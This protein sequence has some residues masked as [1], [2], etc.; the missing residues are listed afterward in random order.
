M[1]THSLFIIL[2]V[3][4]GGFLGA[5][6]RY[7]LGGCVMQ[8]TLAA[9]FPWSTFAV[10][11]LGCILMGLLAGAMER[12]DLLY[13]NLRFFLITGILGG[14]TTFSA[15]GLETVYLLRR[16]EVLLAG[17]YAAGSVFV[18]VAAVWVGLRIVELVPRSG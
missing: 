15:F 6:G 2:L 10:N 9:Q 4:C 18:C 11:V 16:G 17:A 8:H 1:L 3:G 12:L 5:A 14:F 7:V 13:P